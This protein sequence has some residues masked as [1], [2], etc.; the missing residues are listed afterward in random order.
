M[1][2]IEPFRIDVPDETLAHIRK[3]VSEY[4]WHEMPEDGG[5]AYGTNLD[6]MKELLRLLAGW[7]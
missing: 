3:R 6:Y 1:K 4:R 7:V 5:W 2:S